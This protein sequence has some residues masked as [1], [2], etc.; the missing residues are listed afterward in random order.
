MRRIFIA[1]Y[2]VVFLSVNL[3]GFEKEKATSIYREKLIIADFDN[4]TSATGLSEAITDDLITLL[5]KTK[6]FDILERDKLQAILKEQSLQLTGAVDPE[7]AV[8]VGQMVGGRY[9]IFGSITSAN[10]THSEQT[11]VEKIT[12]KKTGKVF[13]Q[14][15]IDTTWQGQV[16]VNAR[17]VDIETG[18]VLLGKSMSGYGNEKI[19]RAKEDKTFLQSILSSLSSDADEEK[20]IQEYYRQIDIKV[21]NNAAKNASYQ[22]ATSFLK[23]FPLSGYV[24]GKNEDDDILIDLGT[25]KGLNSEV[26]LKVMGES[27]VIKHPVTGEVM[28]VRTKN[29]GFLKVI[30]LGDSTSVA[31]VVRG[32]DDIKAGTKVEVV[33]PVFIWHRS[34]ASF[35]IPGLG[36][37][38]E[39]RWGSGIL[40]LL[41]ESALAF[42]AYKCYYWSTAEYLNKQNLLDT[43]VW[44]KKGDQYTKARNQ[45]LAGMWVFIGIEALIHI[46]DTIDAG[47]PAEKNNVFA[48]DYREK[49]GSGLV[50]ALTPKEYRFSF[51][52]SFRF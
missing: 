25:E 7:T 33:D 10:V 39:K 51:S 5:V 52:R 21:V 15:Y 14:Q 11:V 36:Q 13:Y 48:S 12:D 26:N 29:M 16:S 1:I 32:D 37:I 47:Y 20:A 4:A 34:L 44:P 18:Q 23:E 31:K 19:R 40:F 45:A 6:R 2:M 38:L 49:A 46:W 43:T 35:L 28:K 9:I 8:K 22:L 41:T 24:L 42:G 17:L 27:E 3:S 30:D 50:M